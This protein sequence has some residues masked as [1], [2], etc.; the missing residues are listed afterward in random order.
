MDTALTMEGV[1]PEALA[2]GLNQAMGTILPLCNDQQK[3]FLGMMQQLPPAQ[4]L[5]QMKSYAGQM[6]EADIEKAV[7]DTFPHVPVE[8][9]LGMYQQAIAAYNFLKTQ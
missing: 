5:Q 2:E 7:H 6:S 9:R 4:F 8:T 1:S 3:A